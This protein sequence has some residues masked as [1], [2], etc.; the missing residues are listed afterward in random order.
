[1]D[2]LGTLLTMRGDKVRG[3]RLITDAAERAPNDP[4][5]QV[6]Y[7]QVLA[8]RGQAG[9]ARELL[10]KVIEQAGDG[11]AAAPAKAALESLPQ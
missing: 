6:H 7:A 10:Q 11:P 5:I 2:T 3:Q 8:E 9:E 1:M 4:G